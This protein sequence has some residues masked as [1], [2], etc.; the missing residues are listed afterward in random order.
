MVLKFRDGHSAR[1]VH[2]MQYVG[3]AS[4]EPIKQFTVQVA[5]RASL[6][7]QVSSRMRAMDQ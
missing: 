7:R 5:A 6:F 4:A 2:W 3:S 1:R